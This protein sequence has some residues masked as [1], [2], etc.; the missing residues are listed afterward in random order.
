MSLKLQCN[1]TIFTVLVPAKGSS[2]ATG[3]SIKIPHPKGRIRRH[4]LDSPCAR[5]QRWMCWSG[6]RWMDG[7][8]IRSWSVRCFPNHQQQQSR[9]YHLE[10]MVD[11]I[12]HNLC[13][14]PVEVRKI[15]INQSFCVAMYRDLTFGIRRY[16]IIRWF[17]YNCY[18]LYLELLRSQ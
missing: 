8:G 4:I 2:Q 15:E 18:C 1:G 3:P 16:Y 7:D 12:F 9:N 17:F 6:C 14:S 13:F 10:Y 11:N 5:L